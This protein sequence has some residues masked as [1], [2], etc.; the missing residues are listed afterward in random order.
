[1]KKIKKFF[2]EN[3]KLAKFLDFNIEEVK[4]GY[5]KVSVVIKEKHLNGANVAHGGVIFSLADYA[6][7]IAS[8]SHGNLA[9]SINSSISIIN[10]AKENDKLI[11]IAKEVSKNHKLGVYEVLVIDSK[12]KKIAL[13]QGMVYIKNWEWRVKGLGYRI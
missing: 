10:G 6:F 13:F 3:D 11:A 4:L 1:M 5:A 9:L 2:E 7:A 8:N 12:G